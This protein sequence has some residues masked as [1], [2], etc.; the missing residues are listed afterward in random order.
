MEMS[1][2]VMRLQVKAALLLTGLLLAWAMS[3][4]AQ[5]AGEQARQDTEQA[6]ETR[7]QTQQLKDSWSE[8]K[9]ELTRRFRA[10]TENVRWLS[11]RKA[12][13]TAEADALDERVA[14]LQRR[15]D[16]AG[17]LEGS[18]QDTLMVIFHRLEESVAASLPFLPQER[19]LRLAD[20]GDELV[21]PDMTAAEKLRRLLE[22][23]QVE[24]GY[25]ATVEVYQ[26]VITVA[27]EEIHADVLRLGRAALFWRTPDGKRVGHFDQAAGR[28]AELPGSDK[29][30][31]NRAMEMAE[32]RR[33][34]ELIDLPLGRIAP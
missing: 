12:E 9:D 28:Y 7:Q 24:T 19:R 6:I 2:S 33:T 13:E 23:L 15:L 3:A 4:P 11:A 34:V 27:E 25:A 8:E 31:L 30:R 5:T 17:R 1:P 20:V 18:M 16:E 22:A 10:A 14:E 26:D 21:R 29:R 32:R